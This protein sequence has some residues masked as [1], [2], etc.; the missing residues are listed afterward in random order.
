MIVRGVS[1]ILFLVACDCRSCTPDLPDPDSDSDTDSD[2]QDTDTQDTETGEPPPCDYPEEEPNNAATDATWV[3][4]EGRACGSFG[5]PRDVDFWKVDLDAEDWL[6]V[7]IDA[8]ELGS[9]AHPVLLLT[10]DDGDEALVWELGGVGPEVV[11]PAVPGTYSLLVTED[12]GLGGE[13]HYNY[14]LLAGT[15]KPPVDWSVTESANDDPEQPQI[16]RDGDAL[17]GGMSD[18]WDQDWYRLDLP[19]GK[20]TVT[21]DIDAWD[22]GSAGNFT[23]VVLQGTDPETAE[24]LAVVSYGEEGWELDPWAEITTM[25]GEPLLLRVAEH[26][27]RS[28]RAYW[29]RLTLQ[30]EAP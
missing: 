1:L 3:P 26:S 19:P 4:L 29:Y 24:D 8:A 13:E 17:L 18:R 12:E 5:A 7:R 14:E 2:T 30:L 21:L 25:G 10:S 15:S 28:G 27:N 20:Q 16:L 22:Y 6:R 23:L 11:L 9:F